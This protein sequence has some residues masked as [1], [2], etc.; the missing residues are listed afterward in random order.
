M[1]AQLAEFD[2]KTDFAK[3]PKPPSYEPTVYADVEAMPPE[4]PGREDP[5][6]SQPTYAN[7]ETT[8]V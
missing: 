7:L 4:L 3:P 2:H 5:D 1:Y 6:S 8:G